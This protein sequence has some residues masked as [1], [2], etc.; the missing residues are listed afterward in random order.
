[1]SCYDMSLTTS[2]LVSVGTLLF[3]AAILGTVLLGRRFVREMVE[4]KH[5]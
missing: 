4:Y 2:I 1:M 3:A 5:D